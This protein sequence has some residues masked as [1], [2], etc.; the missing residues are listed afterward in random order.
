MSYAFQNDPVRPVDDKA[1]EVGKI[2]SGIQKVWNVFAAVESPV[3]PAPARPPVEI[4]FRPTEASPADNTVT[5]IKGTGQ[6]DAEHYFLDGV[7]DITQVAAHEFG[8]HIGLP[9]EYQQSAADHLRQTGEA[10]PVGEVRGDAEPVDIARELHA[11]V[12]SAPR[13]GRGDKAL[14]V[15]QGHGLTQGAFAQQVARRYVVLFGIGV[16]DDV[17]ANVDEAP[18]EPEMTKQRLL[19]GRPECPPRRTLRTRDVRSAPIIPTLPSRSRVV[20]GPSTSARREPPVAPTV[21]ANYARATRSPQSG[22]RIGTASLPQAGGRSGISSP[23][24]CPECFSGEERAVSGELPACV[25]RVHLSEHAT[26][27]GDVTP[28]S[29]VQ[30]P[31]DR[32]RSRALVTDLGAHFPRQLP[33]TLAL[34]P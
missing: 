31:G 30:Q 32:T 3:P 17:N 25:G 8:H 14:A 20:I 18:T 6:T 24:G 13:A 33:D 4:D 11:A 12:H 34:C 15:V 28:G 7:K 1:A 2:L 10:A 16:V 27:T 19:Q 21:A 5:L 22:S 29:S 9:D 26:E 23:F